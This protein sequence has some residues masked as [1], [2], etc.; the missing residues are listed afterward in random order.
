[1]V[2]GR[3]RE[4][5][6]DKALERALKVFWRKGYEG[7]TLP[8]L[9]KAMGINR[10]SL[11]AA[12]GNKEA[13]FRK[14]MDRYAQGPAAFVQEAVREPSARAVV[15]RVLEGTVRLITDSR[16]PRGCFLVQG[17]LACG[18]SADRVR[19]EMAKRRD[20]TMEALCKRFE[21]AVAEKD[22]PADCNPADFARFVVTVLH[23]LSVQAA[24]GASR[25]ELKRAADIALRAWPA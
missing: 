5:D 21:R 10:P 23:G 13:L 4:F 24:G 14:A 6:V 20:C 11:Y 18:N 2:T 16:N 8:D 1:V 22:L 25:D 9:T 15:E 7:A 17:A 12:F 3:P 19:R